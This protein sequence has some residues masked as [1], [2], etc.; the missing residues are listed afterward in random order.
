MTTLTE[1][2]SFSKKSLTRVGQILAGIVA[3][4]IAFKIIGIL[5]TFVSPPN[6]A[7]ATV[8]FSKL[9]P[10]DLTG[11]IKLP[12]SI[13]IKV[14]TV[15]GTIP[16]LSALAK[17][18]SFER[19]RA[20]FSDLEEVSKN[21]LK[22]GFSPKSAELG[23]SLTKFVDQKDQDRILTIE[24]ISGNF[25]LESQFLNKPELAQSRPNSLE[26]AES[27]ATSLMRNFGLPESAYPKDKITTALYKVDNGRLIDAVSLSGANVVQVIFGRADLDNIHAYPL[28]LQ[29]PQVWGLVSERSVLAAEKTTTA[30]EKQKFA[31]YPL[32]GTNA[33]YEKLKKGQGV[34]NK[35]P[36]NNTFTIR[37]VEIGYV[38]SRKIQKYLQPVYVFRGD[39]NV[40][41]YVG[42]VSDLWIESSTPQ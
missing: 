31:T 41:A 25:K 4:F 28:N 10:V 14:E 32:V 40:M 24:I 5:F 15:T 7:P 16:S 33:A 1:T 6:P 3:L 19:N 37:D 39:D 13:E 9:P 18:F 17:V 35:M 21:A 29:D 27:M 42:A 22:A 2:A 20:T 11:G 8:A 30:I 26:D 12:D 34:F 23:N 38:D 36:K